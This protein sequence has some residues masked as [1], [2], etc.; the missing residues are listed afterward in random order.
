MNENNQSMNIDNE[1]IKNP[2]YS[3]KFLMSRDLFYDFCYVDY[4]R[5]K[6]VFVA[7]FCI[8]TC[9]IGIYLLI[10]D[11]DI[12]NAIC[13]LIVSCIMT[14]IF[15]SKKYGIKVAYEKMVSREGKEL[16]FKYEFFDDKIVSYNDE[17]KKEFFYHQITKFFETKNFIMLQIQNNVYISIEKVNV[18]IDVND[19]KDFFI[20]KCIN[21]KN[22]KFINCVND[23]KMALLFLVAIISVSV[24]GM[25]VGL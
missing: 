14:Y 19:V 6:N 4:N 10:N 9:Y 21:V 17:V 1:Q 18:N 7:F 11:Y 22:K 3:S 25:I 15:F 2:V 8:L 16:N 20:D 24:Y 13:T 12:I 23:K 5:I